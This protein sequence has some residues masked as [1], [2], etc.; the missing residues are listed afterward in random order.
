MTTW[1][2]GGGPRLTDH[3]V[4]E[5][6]SNLT[7]YSCMIFYDF[8]HVFAEF[9][10]DDS[11]LL[12]RLREESHKQR[13]ELR[14]TKREL[15]QKIVD[16]EAVSQHLFKSKLIDSQLFVGPLVWYLALNFLLTQNLL[17]HSIVLK[18]VQRQLKY[19]IYLFTSTKGDV[20]NWRKQL[21]VKFRFIQDLF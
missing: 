7:L 2:R 17:D 1:Q 5:I 11:K 6:A 21:Q 10:E 12:E 9:E 20:A 8:S 4:I 15:Q 13:E 16:C 18:P 3:P 19:T 14:T